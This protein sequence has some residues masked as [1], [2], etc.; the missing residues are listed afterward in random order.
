MKQ[1]TVKPITKFVIA[2]QDTC[3]KLHYRKIVYQKISVKKRMPVQGEFVIFPFTSS[4]DGFIYNKEH[5]YFVDFIRSDYT[6]GLI[7]VF[8]KRT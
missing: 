3:I 2:I 7:T 4:M 5:T 1:D 8:L 6:N